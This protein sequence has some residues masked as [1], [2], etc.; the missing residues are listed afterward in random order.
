M[1]EE[2]KVIV[3]GGCSGVAVGKAIK[4]IIAANEGMAV[5]CD[6]IEP[7]WFE[8]TNHREIKQPVLKE[9][10]NPYGYYRKFE[11]RNKRKNFK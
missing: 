4:A 3:I 11:K 2:I 9:P 7:E 1:T 6:Q 5:I 8:F 10:N